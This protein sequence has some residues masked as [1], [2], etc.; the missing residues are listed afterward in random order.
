MV[1][2]QQHWKSRDQYFSLAKQAMGRWARHLTFPR[3]LSFLTAEDADKCSP[4]WYN[5]TSLFFILK[6]IVSTLLWPQGTIE[7]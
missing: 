2:Q 4:V 5:V 6:F 7:P 3:L 1:L